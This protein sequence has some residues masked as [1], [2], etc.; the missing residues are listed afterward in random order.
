MTVTN[1]AEGRTPKRHRDDLK[2][3]PFDTQTLDELAKCRDSDSNTSYYYRSRYDIE[4]YEDFARQIEEQHSDFERPF[5]FQDSCRAPR[6]PDQMSRCCEMDEM[7]SGMENLF[8][9]SAT[10]SPANKIWQSKRTKRP[11]PH[12]YNPDIITDFDK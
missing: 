5:L 6:E 1:D 3:L 4:N 9:N 12:H 11:N 10:S 2:L 8:L 7:M